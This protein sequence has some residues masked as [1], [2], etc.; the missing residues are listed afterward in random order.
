MEKFKVDSM[1]DVAVSMLDDMYEDINSEFIGFYEDVNELMVELL[2]CDDVYPESIKLCPEYINGYDKEYTLTLCEGGELWVKPTWANGMYLYD[3]TDV[4]YIAD[5]C[6][7]KILENIDYSYAY[8]TGYD[9]EDEDEYEDECDGD[10]EN[11]ELN[12]SDVKD[13]KD[14]NHE[15]VT[16]IARDN[17]G[18]L[19]GFEKSWTTNEDGMH[20][21]SSYTFYSN[22]EEMLQSM[23]K[24]FDI[25][26]QF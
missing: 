14:D 19:R 13:S 17:E 2:K 22:N 12:K 21:S 23:L 15:I 18:K 9:F 1:K 25:I 4:L 16:R 7:S 5:D 24:N 8:E 3:K 26:K 20:Y 11:C 6:N 10:C